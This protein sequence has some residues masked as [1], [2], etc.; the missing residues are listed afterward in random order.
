MRPKAQRKSN[1]AVGTNVISLAKNKK[2][3]Q[4]ADLLWEKL[5]TLFQPL[6]G[7]CLETERHHQSIVQ[8][9]Q[10]D[11]EIRNPDEL[12][13]ELSPINCRWAVDDLTRRPAAYLCDMKI[14]EVVS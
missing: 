11:A 3:K 6:D 12:L 5:P 13:Q 14:S 8:V 2:E 7:A 10:V 1:T 9:V 4:T